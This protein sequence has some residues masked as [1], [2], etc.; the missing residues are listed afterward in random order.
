MRKIGKKLDN[1]TVYNYFKSKGYI[2]LEEYQNSKLAMQ[3]EKDGY[4]YKISY[5]NLRLGKNPSLWGFNNINNLECN[6]SILLK[7][8]Q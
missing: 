8:K 1:N 4:R 3:C 7:E 5:D 2:L 6:I